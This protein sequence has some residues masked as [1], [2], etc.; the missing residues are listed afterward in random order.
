MRSDPIRTVGTKGHPR[1]TTLACLAT[2]ATSA[3]LATSATSPTS[4]TPATSATAWAATPQTTNAADAPVGAVVTN[5]NFHIW[6][7][8]TLRNRTAEIVVVPAIGRVMR[9]ALRDEKG[10]AGP[11]PLWS[12]P[13]IGNGDGGGN[14]VGN[15]SRKDASGGAGAGNGS[16]KDGGSGAATG[17]GGGTGSHDRNQAGTTAGNELRP[18]SEGWINYGGD[19]AWPAPQADWSKVAGHGW[20]PPKAFD[21]VPFAA[22]IKG[23]QV[24]LLS[25][26]D[27]DYGVRVRRTIALDPRKPVMTIETTYEKVQGAPVTVGVWTITQ[28][29]SPERLFVQLPA[30]QSPAFP[31]GY[32]SLLP[33]LPLGLTV[34]GRLLSLVRDPRNKTM[35]SSDGGPLLWVGDGL[36]LLIEDTTPGSAGGGG[37]WPNQGA[38]SQIYTAPGQDRAGA[39]GGATGKNDSGNG[40]NGDQP[41]VELELLGRLHT[42]RGGESATMRSR[43]TL[44]RRTH[45]DPLAEAKKVLAQP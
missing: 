20:P 13:K 6:P 11:G 23:T 8:I 24:Q 2:L 19:K 36:D 27:S 14:G 34:R 44:I 42:L 43:Y 7:A 32:T 31:N 4:A 30:H 40:K 17:A 9:F 33:D 5:T 12:H 28:L 41:Y 21:S 15:G 39:D 10:A 1:T 3:A 18:D 26:V 25:A 35:I 38:R 16:R 22:T 29:A 45:Q 37:A